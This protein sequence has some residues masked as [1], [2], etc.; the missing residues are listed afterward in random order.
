MTELKPCVT[1]EHWRFKKFTGC[2]SPASFIASLIWLVVLTAA[3]WFV[4]FKPLLAFT[5]Y[6]VELTSAVLQAYEPAKVEGSE[7]RI[8][9][10]QLS[11]QDSGV[12]NI[13]LKS[14]YRNEA[15]KESGIDLK[16]PQADISKVDTRKV[17][18]LV[19]QAMR[20]YT[21]LEL[22]TVLQSNSD[23]WD[24]SSKPLGSRDGDEEFNF[25]VSMINKS[26]I[27]H[28]TTLTQGQ[29]DELAACYKK[30]DEKFSN[31]FMLLIHL[32][33]VGTCTPYGQ[34][35][36]SFFGMFKSMFVIGEEVDGDGKE[37]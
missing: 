12:A 10:E 34:H 36:P 31:P 18:E 9:L 26:K 1:R 23:I 27:D 2:A 22:K 8:K 28:L 17:D 20:E 25:S 19:L 16:D 37:I 13:I 35:E 4:F 24:G 6:K 21:D 29:K 11:H 30:L 32:R 14:L 3:T 7:G 5:T 15:I 33:A